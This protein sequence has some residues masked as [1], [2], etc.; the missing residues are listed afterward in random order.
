MPKVTYDNIEFDSQNEVDFYCW[1]I[2]AKENNLIKSFEYQPISFD[3]SDEIKSFYTKTRKLKTKTVTK[4]E[5]KAMLHKHVYTPDFII[6]GLSKQFKSL[7]LN[8]PDF[9]FDLNSFYIDTKGFNSRY[10]DKASFPIN[11]KWVYQLHGI[12]VA[13]VIPE[14]WF[15]KTWVPMKVRLTD[16]KKQVQKK[17]INTKTIS[18][19]IVK[20]VD[21]FE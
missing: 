14:K 10:G 9:I 1:L 2:E 4:Q 7:N 5:T 6:R 18:E 3:L 17:Y 21:L 12:F 13:K 20:H 11:Q 8:L 16:K 19:F 15:K